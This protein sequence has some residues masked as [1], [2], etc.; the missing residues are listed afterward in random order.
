[1]RPEFRVLRCW[2]CATQER[3]TGGSHEESV[4]IVGPRRDV[5]GVRLWAGWEFGSLRSG[6]VYARLQLSKRGS[7]IL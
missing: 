4:F 2:L 7:G 6:L 1:M 5:C 3:Q